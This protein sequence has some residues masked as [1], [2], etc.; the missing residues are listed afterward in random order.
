MALR[1]VLAVLAGLAFVRPALAAQEKFGEK[2]GEKPGEESGQVMPGAF[3][4]L[5][6][7]LAN[8]FLGFNF[9][10]HLT[11]VAATATMTSQD[12]DLRVH[13][14]FHA[15]SS[16]GHAAYPV[17][18]LGV[19]GPVVLF[20][21]LHVAGRVS[22]NPETVGAAFSVL[23]S[24]ALT[25]GYV[26]LL[27]LVVGRPAPRDDYV[28]AVA[29][30][31][32]KL[33]RTFRLGIYRG[34]VIAGWPSGHVAVTTAVLSSLAAY[35]PD[36]FSLKVALVLGSAGMMLGVSSFESGGMHW[37]SDAVAGALMALPMGLSTGQGMRRLVQG[38]RARSDTAWFIGP[39]LRAD[40]TG[41]VLGRAF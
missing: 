15:H 19:A 37:A 33:S 30:D 31:E 1:Y 2:S 5:A 12:V 38:A 11:A 21:G 7:N 16:W 29:P 32:E 14:Y 40:M 18:I 34:G 27:K 13:N 41:A 3:D 39:S 23:Q 35:Y 9:G 22:G 6:R 17:A 8:S 28:P 10:F 25:L 36:S 24:A 4:G 20:G 26:T